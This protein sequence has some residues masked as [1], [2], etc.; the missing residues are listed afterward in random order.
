MAQVC[1]RGLF[2]F[3]MPLRGKTPAAW[4]RF[5]A[6]LEKRGG[7]FSAREARHRINACLNYGYAVTLANLTRALVGLGFDPAFGFLQAEKPGRLNLACDAIK[8]LRPKIDACVFQWAAGRTFERKDFI[9]LPGGQV[10]LTQRVASDLTSRVLERVPSDESE[11]VAR[12][13]AGIA[14]GEA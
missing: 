4:K 7:S 12:W 14:A 5:G 11:G 3:E 6:R 13:L 10:L 9:E 2:G 1:W 8:P